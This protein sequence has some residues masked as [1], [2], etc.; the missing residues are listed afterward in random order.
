VRV[1]ART[2]PRIEPLVIGR[3]DVDECFRP[4]LPG[5]GVVRA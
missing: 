1:T 3:E 2:L 4:C 5:F